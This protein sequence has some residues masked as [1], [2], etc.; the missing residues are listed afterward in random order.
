MAQKLP[1]DQLELVNNFLRF[2]RRNSTLLDG[3]NRYPLG[4]ILNL[5]ETPVLFEFLAEYT[6]YLTGSKTI[7]GKT[8]RSGWGKRQATLILYIFADGSKP[9]KP[10]LL[11]HGEENGRILVVESQHHDP[12]VTVEFNPKAYNNERAFTMWLESEYAPYRSQVGG[13]FLMVLDQASFHRTPRILDYLRQQ[14]TIPAIV[15]FG[16][17]P[18]VQPLDTRANKAFEDQLGFWIADLT[19]RSTV[20]G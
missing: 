10:K 1:I 16:C 7:S 20:P 13:D 15:P 4:S 5:D 8:L 18:L 11:F 6:Y 2:I 17:T 14:S 3:F 19:A 9:I 12:G